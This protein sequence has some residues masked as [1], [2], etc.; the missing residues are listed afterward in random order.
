MQ[1]NWN[2]GQA[3]DDK[4]GDYYVTAVDG[5]KTHVMAGPFRNDHAEALRAVRPTM[6]RACSLDGR[7]HF[8]SWGTIR[9]DH[10]SVVKKPVLNAW[11]SSH[12]FKIAV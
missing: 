10:G 4:L 8:M 3:P 9:V 6:D 7:S 11:L 12:G 1:T 2:A 5:S